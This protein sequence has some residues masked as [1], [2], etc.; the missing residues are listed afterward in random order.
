MNNYG[1]IPFE[2]GK[3]LIA[4]VKFIGLDSDYEEYDETV[5]RPIPKS[6]FLKAFQ[7]Q[8]TNII[9]GEKFYGYK[10][11]KVVKAM[12]EILSSKGYINAEVIAF[13]EILPKNQLNLVFSVREDCRLLFRKFVLKII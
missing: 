3:T 7:E 8:R 1:H 9:A 6:E 2:D 12:R 10:V 13:G 11:S 5:G 4:E